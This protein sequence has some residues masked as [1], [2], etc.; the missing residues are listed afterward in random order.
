MYC[1]VSSGDSSPGARARA[2][3]G[4]RPARALNLSVGPSPRGSDRSNGILFSNQWSSPIVCRVVLDGVPT[5]GDPAP[6][7]GCR[8]AAAHHGL[9]GDHAKM[10]KCVLHRHHR[11][12]AKYDRQQREKENLRETEGIPC[13]P[14]EFGI[15]IKIHEINSPYL[16][17]NPALSSCYF[18]DACSLQ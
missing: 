14:F 10:C 4:I 15:S 12:Q 16:S 18:D 5:L 2:Y 6:A 8:P 9:P 11:M 17:C 3:R 13:I 7:R 1:A